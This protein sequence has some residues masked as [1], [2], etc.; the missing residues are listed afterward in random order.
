[1]TLC[2]KMLI[3]LNRGRKPSVSR[4]DLKLFSLIRESLWYKKK[5]QNFSIQEISQISEYEVLGNFQLKEINVAKSTELTPKQK[6]SR[7]YHQKQREKNSRF[8]KIIAEEC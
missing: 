5:M 1:M 8:W 4:T 3:C 7:K 2:C 6:A